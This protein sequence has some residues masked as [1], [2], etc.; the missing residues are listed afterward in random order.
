KFSG[1]TPNRRHNIQT[2]MNRYQ[3]V[4]IAPGE[5]FSFNERLGEVDGST[6]YKLE[7]VIKSTGTVPEF[8]GGVCQVSSTVFKSALLAGLPIDE[9]SPHSY[10]V[11]YYAQID[12]HG[13]D[14][15]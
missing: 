3:G 7:L 11:S 15:T 12:G 14:A 1:S 9:R 10:A 4:L 5:T 6:G 8:G 13:L 2:S